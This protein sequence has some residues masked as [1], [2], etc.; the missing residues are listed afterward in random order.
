MLNK[1]MNLDQHFICLCKVTRAIQWHDSSYIGK[2]TPKAMQ[3][4]LKASGWKEGHTEYKAVEK[5]MLP[6]FMHFTKGNPENP[7]SIM[8][9]LQQQFKDYYIR[10]IEWATD[11]SMLSNK[12][13]S[14]IEIIA[15]AIMMEDK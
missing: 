4:I 7:E 5:T 10:V 15:E 8:I 11:L 6:V 13:F 2:V 9:P 14:V 3:S 1:A 12:T